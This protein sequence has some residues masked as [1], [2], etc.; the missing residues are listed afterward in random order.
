MNYTEYKKLFEEISAAAEPQPPYNDARYLHYTKLNQARM[1][2]WDKQL[3]IDE[4]CI[5]TFRNLT[6]PQ[7]WIII[8]EPWCGDAAHVVPVLM[9]L[10]AAS[11]QI[12]YDIQLRDSEP[13]LISSYLTH[14]TKSIPK[15]IVRDNEGQ[16]L[17]VWG[18]R[19]EAAQKLRDELIA[20]QADMDTLINALQNWYN[21][22]KGTAICAE[23]AAFY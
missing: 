4:Q 15:L 12:T 8:T 22:D 14:S 11:G 19:P 18:P 3:L 9:K 13:F 21:Q 16:D 17:F 1:N 10:A 23:L 7:H 2:R 20:Q 5:A 6:A